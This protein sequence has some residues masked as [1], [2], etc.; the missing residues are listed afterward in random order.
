MVGGPLRLLP[1]LVRRGGAITRACACCVAVPH[2][3]L[4]VLRAKGRLFGC[5]GTRVYTLC[6][7]EPPTL[8]EGA[9][10]ITER[11]RHLHVVGTAGSL[12]DAHRT[13]VH[14][15]GAIALHAV[16]ALTVPYA[17]QVATNSQHLA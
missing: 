11:D 14:A 6:L 16:H 8:G 2:S 13:L 7:I 15:H 9:T 1:L 5:Q 4:W 17:L 12:L 3:H 10:E